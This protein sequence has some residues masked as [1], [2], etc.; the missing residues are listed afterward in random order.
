MSGPATGRR[1]RAMTF[2]ALLACLALIALDNFPAAAQTVTSDLFR[3][4][5]D[6]FMSP[7]DSPLRKVGDI[8]DKT[9]DA[10]DDV[11][12]RD[13]D[14]PAPSRIGKIPTYGLPAANG[15]SDSGFNPLNR[16]RNQ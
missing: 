15:A 6:G 10:A 4:A 16:T 2:R 14:V 9:G 11:R 3:P 5:R 7:Q 1:K 12:L 13:K 8:S